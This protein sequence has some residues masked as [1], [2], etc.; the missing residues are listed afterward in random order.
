MDAEYVCLFAVW[1][2]GGALLPLPRTPYMVL[3]RLRGGGILRQ[4]T[5]II[6]N[7]AYTCGLCR[8]VPRRSLLIVLHFFSEV[9]RLRCNAERRLLLPLLRTVSGEGT[10]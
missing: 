9:G 7:R 10:E 8:Q 6:D 1:C 3:R 5:T 2:S 4:A